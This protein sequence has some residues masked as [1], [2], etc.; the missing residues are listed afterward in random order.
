MHS[1]SF[2]GWSEMQIYALNDSVHLCTDDI[3]ILI[4]PKHIGYARIPAVLDAPTTVESIWELERA[5]TK[6]IP[7]PK[8]THTWMWAYLI[9]PKVPQHEGI[10][11]LYYAYDT[12]DPQHQYDS[13]FN[14]QNRHAKL[15]DRV[16]GWK[17]KGIGFIAGDYVIAPQ[18]TV[19]ICVGPYAEDGMQYRPHVQ[20]RDSTGTRIL[21]GEGC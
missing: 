6:E 12:R 17:M 4:A 16:S 2:E 15:Q 7:N 1:K 20:I 14:A 18:G 13:V 10:G 9:S 21:K 5:I 3:I 8:T 19:S 11:D